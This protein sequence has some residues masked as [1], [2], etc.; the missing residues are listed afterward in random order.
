MGLEFF[1]SLLVE[2]TSV[3][4]EVVRVFLEPVELFWVI[5]ILRVHAWC[6]LG[7]GLKNA[8][9]RGDPGR[10]S[11]KEINMTSILSHIR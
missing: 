5:I 10:G 8:G 4:Q 1:N 2:L 9:T 3:F 11:R 6:P 7:V